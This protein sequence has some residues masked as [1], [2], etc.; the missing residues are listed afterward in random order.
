MSLKAET[1]NSSHLFDQTSLTR[2]SQQVSIMASKA[3]KTIR[4]LTSAHVI[5]LHQTAI[6]RALPSQTVMLDSAI[7]SPENVNY[8]EKVDNIFHLAGNAKKIVQNHSYQ[9][10]NKRTAP[11]C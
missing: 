11:G 7:A 1:T 10:G 2:Q 6:A 3:A 8:F 9:D 4:F 5:R